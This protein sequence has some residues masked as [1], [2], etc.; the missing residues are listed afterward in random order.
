MYAKWKG[1]E[2]YA[3]FGCFKLLKTC[4]VIKIFVVSCSTTLELIDAKR[5]NK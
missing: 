4:E 5:V 3:F 2:S 1:I